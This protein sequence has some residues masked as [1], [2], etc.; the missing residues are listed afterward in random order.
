MTFF[1]LVRKLDM[2]ESITS[3]NEMIVQLADLF[4]ELT[5]KEARIVSY[6]LLG[7]L[8]PPY[9]GT[10][11]GVAEKMM[12][13]A[14]VRLLAI[15]NESE[16]K[17]KMQE[18]GDWG[19][20]IASQTWKEPDS[21]LSIEAIYASLETIEELSGTGSQSEK[22]GA[23]VKLFSEMTPNEAKYIVRIILGK[24]R[25]G[26]SDM[27]ILDALSW[28]LVGSKKLKNTLED[29]YNKCT[30]IG[31]IAEIVL[32][33]GIEGIKN[34]QIEVGIPIR[35]AAAER[36]NTTEEIIEKLGP[37]VAQPKLD[38][39]RV[40]IHI[41]NKAEKITFFSRHLTNIS[42]MF[43]DLIDSLHAVNA[44]TLIVEGEAIGYDPET[45]EFLPF[46]ETV[47]RRRKHDIEVAKSEYP[48][49]LFLFDV[50][51]YNDTSYLDIPHQKRRSLLESLFPDSSSD[52]N[53][54]CIAEKKIHNAE[55]LEEYFLHALAQ[56]LEGLVAKRPDAVY[57]AGK[58]NFNWI[59]FKRS[60]KGSTLSDTID[61]VIIGYYYGR[62]KRAKF[63]LGALLVAVYNH[64]NDTYETI[65]KLGT[66][67]SDEQFIAVKKKL[68]A[69][70]V[71]K[72]PTSVVCAKEL[73]PD[74]W[75]NPGIVCEVYADEI[76]RSP[77]HAAGKTEKESG[78][79]LRF[80]RFIN[81]REDKGATEA[82]TSEEVKHMFKKSRKSGVR[83]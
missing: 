10:Q 21:T 73:T 52:Q 49:K 23:L 19:T 3:R 41:D 70:K 71:D 39:F 76:T 42:D 30:D 29:S 13:S 65:A 60:H 7:E 79:A 58:R 62:G 61:V 9:I 38:G 18:R 15:S 5:G 33:E 17:E 32:S 59:K 4:K 56:G 44:K 68:D 51:Y 46:Q 2:L 77:I 14:L 37:C 57:Q 36:L 43:P 53:V 74:V 82:T 26:F 69:M 25:L 11:F 28:Y 67:F 75:I 45:G 12:F 47:K 66:G 78:L 40:Q 16:L 24:L 83:E 54:L 80:P 35:P 6:F 81:Y 64:N 1:A 8:H 63:G 34:I 50:L 55:E 31:R 22:I 20:V 27:T 72:K 48:L